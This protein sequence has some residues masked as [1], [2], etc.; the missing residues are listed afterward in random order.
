MENNTYIVK[1][2]F[3]AHSIRFL[4]K[5]KYETY[6]DYV[7]KGRCIYVFKRTKKFE[8]AMDIINAALKEIREIEN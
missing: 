3:L 1:S 5:E 8:R 6:D 2:L 7:D 4:T